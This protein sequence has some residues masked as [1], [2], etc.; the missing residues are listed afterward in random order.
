MG[1]KK[2]N[3]KKQNKKQIILDEKFKELERKERENFYSRSW[4]ILTSDGFYP[5]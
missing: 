1:Y 3:N 2:N 4:R 5:G